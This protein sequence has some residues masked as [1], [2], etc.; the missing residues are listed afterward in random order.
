VAALALGAEGV[1]MGTRFAACKEC[2]FHPRLKD[3]FTQL[4]ERDTMLVHRTINNLER[5]VRTDF[6]QKILNMEEKGAAL[7]EILPLIAGDKVRA[8]YETGDTASA[9][10]T[11]GQSVGLIHDVPS[12]KEIIEGMV[13]QAREIVSRMDEKVKG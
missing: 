4:T 7:D 5:V 8:A 1:M 11:A 9:M 6:T 2:H 13:K 10:I 3:W 12:V